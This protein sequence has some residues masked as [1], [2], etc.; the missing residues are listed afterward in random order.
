[1]TGKTNY[2]IVARDYMAMMNTCVFKQIRSNTTPP[3]GPPHAPSKTP[4]PFNL[5]TNLGKP[6][7]FASP[8]AVSPASS[9]AFT[10]RRNPSL[11]G[12]RPANSNSA[13]PSGPFRFATAWCSTVRFL[14]ST[15]PY[16][17]PYASKT[18]AASAWFLQTAS[19]RAVARLV[20]L[21]WLRKRLNL[22]PR[23]ERSAEARSRRRRRAGRWLRW[24][25]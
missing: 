11:S 17:G 8:H 5:C 9:L 25:A 14:A 23:S 15:S 19:R 24:A 4:Q 6:N 12:S 18:W 21:C 20:S 2:I 16:A 22:S 1:M 13:I 7:R 10:N 3:L